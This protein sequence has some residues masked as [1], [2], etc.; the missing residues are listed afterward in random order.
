MRRALLAALLFCLASPAAWADTCLALPFFNLTRNASLDW[1]GESVAEAVHDGLA[2]EGFMTHDR[3]DRVEA[4]RRLSIRPYSLL[5]KAAVIKIGETLDAEKVLF[6]QFELTA[7]SKPRSK[8]TL[9]L[10]AWIL[11]LKHLKQSP[12]IR[13]SG[14]IE[15]LPDLQE[16]L[17]WQVLRAL[18]SG[19]GPSESDFKAR[20]ASVRV[21]AIENYIRGLLAPN[22][23]EQ[24]RFFTQAARLDPNYSQPSFQ[25]GRLQ[26]K[27]KEYKSAGDW[28]QKVGANDV[29]YHEAEFFLGLCRYYTGDFAAAQTAFQ[30]VARLV[31]LNE[32]YNNLGAAQSRANQPQAP[33]SF[34][35][36]LD[37]D[38][39]DP[40]YQF[41]LGYALWKQGKFDEA[42]AKFRAVLDRNP[43]DE[44]AAMLLA[45]CDAQS[46]P[47][48]GDPR[49]EGLER[50][51]TTY[52]E[53]AYWQL[54]ALLQPDKL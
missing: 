40:A 27:K 50:L 25:L 47:R 52:E 22:A 33:D 23:D 10:A 5:T 32:V 15:T 41:N 48:S 43:N 20:H 53:S 29:H 34:R 45:R 30:T 54:K 35:K 3:D 8:G 51:K 4:Y 37:G 31:P 49:T 9:H 28:F 19:G 7:A 2:S 18:R 12:A 1:I 11:D 24:H 26:W 17:A 42:T 46:G 6:G 14:A 16:H 44:Q 13:E 38:P 21:D 39:S 36:A